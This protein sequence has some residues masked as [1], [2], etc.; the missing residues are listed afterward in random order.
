MPAAFT[1]AYLSLPAGELRQRAAEAVAGLSDCAFCPRACH[2]D[3]VNGVPGKCLTGRH[4]LLASFGP[5]HGEEDCL[6][7]SRGSGTIF[8]AACNLHCVFCQNYDISWRR[9][10]EPIQAEPLAEIML[11]LQ[12]RGCHNLNLVTPSHVVPQILEALA[13][14]VERELLIPVVYN[15]SGYDRVETL[16][17][18]DGVVDIYMPDFK[19]WEA[20]TASRY[21]DAGDYP[22][23]A[24]EALRE[25]HRQTGPLVLDESGLARRGVLLRHLVMPGGTA[26][27][28]ETMRWVARELSAETFVNIMAQYRPAGRVRGTDYR[29]IGRLI[30]DREYL[31]ALDD[32]RGAGIHR[33]DPGSLRQAAD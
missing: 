13:I 15:T 30:S 11:H 32:A 16:R 8:F 22:Q 3:R 5:H 14:A 1:A 28:R 12:R 6:R 33:F 9:E 19:F 24:R 25:M 21:C 29:E 31:Q 17:L 4:A 27:T 10:G 20:Q 7:G 26:G 18:L 23:V 2:A